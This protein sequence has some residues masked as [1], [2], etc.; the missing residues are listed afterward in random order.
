LAE[1]TSEKI[2]WKGSWLLYYCLFGP[3]RRLIFLCG[4]VAIAENAFLKTTYPA[5]S[6]SFFLDV[7]S[8]IPFCFSP[9][10]PVAV[11]YWIK[12][13]ASRDLRSKDSGI[14]EQSCGTRLLESGP[15]D[16]Q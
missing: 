1:S 4:T 16:L 15:F 10:L 7:Y 8:S 11:Q 2:N 13:L 6:S 3:E 5:E 12:Y 14:Q 9:R